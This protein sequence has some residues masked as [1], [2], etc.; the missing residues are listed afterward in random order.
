M[1][2]P[3]VQMLPDTIERCFR[4]YLSACTRQDLY[5]LVTAVIN[6]Y[7]PDTP[8]HSVLKQNVPEHVETLSGVIQKFIS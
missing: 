6:V 3:P 8:G 4:Y 5:D 7:D 1:L 2:K